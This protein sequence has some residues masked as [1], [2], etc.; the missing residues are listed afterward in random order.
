MILLPPRLHMMI[1]LIIQI[2]FYSDVRIIIKEKYTQ[3]GNYRNLDSYKYVANTDHYISLRS[4]SSE[5]LLPH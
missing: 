2:M 1:T 4:S 5:Q 3:Q